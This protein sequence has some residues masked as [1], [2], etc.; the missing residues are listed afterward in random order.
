M[1]TVL[2]TGNA[3]TQSI[4]GVGFEPDLLWLKCR[5]GSE[6]H[7]VVDSVRGDSTE[8]SG[9]KYIETQSTTTTTRTLQQRI[10]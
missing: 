9:Y 1:N 5:T 2:Y 8:N 4:T 3:S 10:I 7:T 6:N